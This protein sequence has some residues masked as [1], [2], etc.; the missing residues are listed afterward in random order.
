[1]NKCSNKIWIENIGDLFCDFKLLPIG[2]MT[3][4]AK[5][6]SITRLI[7]FLFILFLLI[8]DIKWSL[9]F[10]L[11][12]LLIIIIFY[13]I[14]KDKK[15]NVNKK[16]NSK[17]NYRYP[18]NF[19]GGKNGYASKHRGIIEKDPITNTK[20]LLL[21][22]PTA[23]RFCNDQV[24]SEFNDTKYMSINQQLVG[25]GNP[26]TLIPPVVVPPSHDL[27]YWKANNLI[28][29]SHINEQSQYDVYQ[30]GYQVSNCCD[31]QLYDPS[32][33]KYDSYTNKLIRYPVPEDMQP[34]YD[35][36]KNNYE[37]NKVFIKQDI[38]EN[39]E[40]KN[41]LKNIEPVFEI[42]PNESGQVNVSCGYNP[43]QLFNAGLPTNF[44]SGNCQK[45]RNFKN[46]NQN[47][48][49]QTIQPGVYTTNQID[50]PINSNIGISFTQQFEPLTVQSKN[51]EIMYTQHD[52]RIFE[53][54][55][56][57]P[58]EETVNESNVY[59]PRF[60]GY[61]SS[62][63][64]YTDDLLG[65]TRFMYD[66][67]DAVRMPNYISRNKIDFLPYADT[68]GPMKG[69]DGLEYTNRIKDMAQ[70]SW[71]ENSL[72]FRTGLQQSLL[73]KRNSEMW[74]NRYMPKQSGQPRILGGI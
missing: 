64:A 4:E 43:E 20:N 12:S 39:F 45:N 65:Q 9:F 62:Y 28:T 25:Q 47:L 68:Y 3:L 36:K 69:E 15:M 46:Y 63:R 7:I 13:Y 24:D 48:F 42:K 58:I 41:N 5:I 51:G 66:D 23:F 49:T 59:D 10:L 54:D 2:N 50:E 37:N 38:K 1:M 52:P 31:E 29:H 16:N 30:S 55:V 60:S 61:G 19:S 73:R 21:E 74:Q 56:I 27:S 33:P 72:N 53:N 18:P 11:I 17:E 71:T 40:L 22:R 14:I 57:E 26:K 67:V 70:N 32:C 8:F 34:S 44:P 35:Y 6:N